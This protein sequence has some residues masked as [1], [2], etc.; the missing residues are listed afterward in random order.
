LPATDLLRTNYDAHSFG[1]RIEAGHRIATQV[2]GVTHA[3]LPR[4]SGVGQQPGRA[5]LQIQQHE[6]DAG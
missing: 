4:I 5:V 2:L 1:G 6:I 3:E